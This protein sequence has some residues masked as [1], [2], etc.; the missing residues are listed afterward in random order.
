MAIR[1]D[2]VYQTVLALANK[3]QRGYITPQEFN[4]FAKQA[5]MEIFE[6]YFYDLNQFKRVPGNDSVNTDME[7][8]IEE[9][10]QIF[11]RET[12]NIPK[13]GSRFPYPSGLYRLTCVRSAGF[14]QTSSLY[15]SSAVAS[16]G[17]VDCEKVTHREYHDAVAS[18]LTRPTLNR[19]IFYSRQNYAYVYPQEINSVNIFYIKKPLN[20]NWTYVVVND[21][22]IYTPNITS[23]DFEL[24]ESEERDLIL[25]ILQLSGITIKDFALVQAAGQEVA[26][27]V[28]QQKQ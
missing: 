3:E 4:L 13:D 17:T 1:V 28:Q 7:T 14:E 8:L 6:Q 22:A 27:V 20:P 12:M 26:N 11:N 19:P 5:Q 10:L 15:S 2:T 16:S 25:K 24:H 21:K 23:Q 9:K 18:Y